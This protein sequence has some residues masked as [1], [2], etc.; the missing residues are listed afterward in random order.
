MIEY[1]TGML[2]A[3]S[4][5]L[6]L[7]GW[8]KERSKTSWVRSAAEDDGGKRDF[9]VNQRQETKGRVFRF[10]R[11]VATDQRLRFEGAMAAE[12]MSRELFTAD[13]W[14]WT[15]EDVDRV[16]EHVESRHLSMPLRRK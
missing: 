1:V 11:A 14:D 15:P 12:K 16:D 10:T 3:G 4:V 8:K 13:G 2:G 5:Q 6:P 9:V 7:A